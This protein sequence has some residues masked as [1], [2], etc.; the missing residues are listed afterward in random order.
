[1]TTT[2]RIIQKIASPGF[3]GF[4]AWTDG[5]D[6]HQNPVFIASF[7]HP[8]E[9]YIEAYVKLYPHQNGLNRGL[10]N[11]I[12]GYLYGHA[13]QVPQPDHAFLAEIP[14]NRLRNID[15]H[16]PT[17]HWL[18]GALKT[19]NTWPGFCSSRL[20]GKSAAVHVPDTEIYAVR[21]DIA[22]WGD[23]PRAV[24]MDEN[25]AH[26]DR[27][28]NNLI[29]L[30]RKKY[31]VIDNGRLVNGNSERWTCDMLD[32]SALYRNRLSEHV[33]A[34]R[35]ADETISAMIDFAQRHQA[36][37]ATIK[38]E[39]EYWLRLLLPKEH[40]DFNSFLSS[41]TE[42]VEWLLRKRYQRLV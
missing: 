28:F 42:S 13:L 27:H 31:A 11:E 23:L 19:T 6:R 4:I 30:G 20:D 2:G 9:G 7:E 21:E 25:I 34:H 17:G 35:P 24:A 8:V 26:V 32:P 40:A 36:A 5:D 14:L 37:F 18:H 39:L 29:R 1:M 15:Q 10:V 12:T 33:W 3:R 41:R 16:L 22:A 38:Q